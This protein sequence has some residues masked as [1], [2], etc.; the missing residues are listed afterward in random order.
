ML[1]ILSY[2]L[3]A[4]Y[5]VG[6]DLKKH[7]DNILKGVCSEFEPLTYDPLTCGGYFRESGLNKKRVHAVI[8]YEYDMVEGVYALMSIIMRE[9]TSVERDFMSRGT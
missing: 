4:A 3:V 6:A 9:A 8:A 7:S 2:R 1:D 5:T